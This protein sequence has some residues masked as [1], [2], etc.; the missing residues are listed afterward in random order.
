MNRYIDHYEHQ[1]GGGGIDR[2]FIGN[3]YQRGHGL[4]SFLSGLF[5]RALP[6]LTRGAR[7]LGKEALHAGMNILGDVAH[8]TPF[9]ESLRTRVRES[10]RNL[11]RKAEESLESLM[12]GSGYKIKDRA[13]RHHSL[14]GHV[15]S[16][17]GLPA[18]ASL[19]SIEPRKSKKKSTKIKKKVSIK[20]KGKKKSSAKGGKS[21]KS[22]NKKK[23]LASKTRKSK[24]V[25]RKKRTVADIFG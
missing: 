17:I 15:G 24:I 22:S 11:K 6:L 4:G 20:R 16:H 18:L 13:P 19:K 1:V 14:F 23:K 21:L 9:K 2:V 8:D 12:R 25:K 5:R 3:P 10:G 7:V